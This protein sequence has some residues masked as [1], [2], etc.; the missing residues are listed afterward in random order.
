MAK[1]PISIYH[2]KPHNQMHATGVERSAQKLDGMN[3]ESKGHFAKHGQIL[4]DNMNMVGVR[5]V[6]Q[7]AS[8]ICLH[9]PV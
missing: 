2:P 1:G 7:P 4:T 8:F 6:M 3:I 9:P 5:N